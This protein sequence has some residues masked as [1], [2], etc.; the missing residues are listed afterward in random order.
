MGLLSF[1]PRRGQEN[2]NGQPVV[3]SL[4]VEFEAFHEQKTELLP[5]II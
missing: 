2:K 5:N 3:K 4:T 1:V